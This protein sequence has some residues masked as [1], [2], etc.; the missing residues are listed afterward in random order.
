MPRGAS[1]KREREYKELKQDFKQ[2]HRYPGREE[3]VAARIVNKQRR[4]H[5]E[6]KAQKARSGRKVH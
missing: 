3:E 1:Q 6:T 2:E 4:E 5:G